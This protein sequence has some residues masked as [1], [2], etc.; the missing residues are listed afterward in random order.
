ML[1]L[2]GRQRSQGDRR[3]RDGTA[4]TAQP[5]PGI[6]PTLNP[7]RSCRSTSARRG[8]QFGR[9][10]YTISGINPEEV[11]AA[12]DAL[13]EKLKELRGLRRA[14]AVRICF[15]TSRTSIST[16]I[17]T[18]PACPEFRSRKLQGLL[19]AAYSQNYVYLIKQPDDQYQVILEVEDADRSKPED[20]RQL[21]VRP[22][23]KD[24]LIPVRTLTKTTTNWGC[25]G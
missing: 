25:R 10:S 6:F 23:G 24:T 17:A 18:A 1:F 3:G 8:S 11:Y 15:G 5:D 7:R 19:R 16:S 20:L 9:Y 21:Y 2:E 14:A 12:A 13:R 4:A 22:D